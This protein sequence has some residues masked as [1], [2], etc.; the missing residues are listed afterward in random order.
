MLTGKLNKERTLAMTGIP[1]RI[2]VNRIYLDLKNPRHVPYTN[3][4]EAIE[5]L[6]QKEQVY[7]LAKNIAENGLNQLEL[8]AL[9]P[10][11]GTKKIT[12]HTSFTVAEGNR[13]MCALK[14]L[15]DPD[16]APAKYRKDFERLAAD[17]QM[18]SEIWGVIY[19]NEAA[20]DPWLETIHNG[21][22]GGI[23][24]RPWNAEQRT[25][26]F[27]DRKNLAS[28]KLLDYAQDNGM[29]TAEE[30]KKK[31]TT[32]QRYIGNQHMKEVIGIDMTA[33]GGLSR[34]RP[35]EE[36][37]SVLNRFMRD[38]VGKKVHSRTNFDDI[39]DYSRE[40]AVSSGVSHKR[41]PSASLSLSTGKSRRKKPKEPQKPKA[42]A[43]EQAVASELARIGSYK[44]ERLYYSI[45]ELDLTKHTL[46]LA[47]GLWAFLET[48]TARC[49]RRPDQ[50]FPDYLDKNRLTNLGFVSR[51]DKGAITEALKRVSA[52]GNTTKHHDRAAFFNSEQLANDVDTLREVLLKLLGTV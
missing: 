24:R 31:L 25:R 23:G 9:I 14:L 45:C 11:P 43:Y 2:N 37:N 46:L 48:L 49:G 19:E 51:E 33:S 8:F 4:A 17:I 47:V 15:N 28:Q 41:V 22:Q 1:Q 32:V 30:R 13:R 29:I 6:C 40:L 39:R 3:Q 5:Y 44:L 26:H 50:A 12:S 16:L 7:A 35:V 18:P 36:F 21:P 27:G 42:I 20:V 52:Y 34:N 38:V 10:L